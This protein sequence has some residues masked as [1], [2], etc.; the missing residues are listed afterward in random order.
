MDGVDDGHQRQEDDA[1]C[2]DDHSWIISM[3]STR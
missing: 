3:V 2:L 1:D